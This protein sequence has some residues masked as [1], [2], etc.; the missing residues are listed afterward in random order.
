MIHLYHRTGVP[1]G[2]Y[3]CI[4]T[5]TEHVIFISKNMLHWCNDR[6][7]SNVTTG[8]MQKLEAS[9]QKKTIKLYVGSSM[10]AHDQHL[11]C[12]Y[13]HYVAKEIHFSSKT[14]SQQGL[15]S[16]ELLPDPLQLS[17][18]FGQGQASAEDVGTGNTQW[19]L[20][21]ST[22]H[23]TLCWLNVYNKLARLILA[24]SQPKVVSLHRWY[25]S[26]AHWLAAS[27]MTHTPDISLPAIKIPILNIKDN[28]SLSYCWLSVP[29]SKHITHTERHSRQ[30]VQN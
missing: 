11:P 9:L 18:Q 30:Y 20:L 19:N 16:D 6:P 5:Q 3:T 1:L 21:G 13:P 15:F 22:E 14:R 12:T 2:I 26:W 24:Q 17:T 8:Y 7:F 25:R 10:W 28:C 27:S 4:L 29:H 23:R